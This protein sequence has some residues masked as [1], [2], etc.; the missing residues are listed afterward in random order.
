[1]PV[2]TGGSSSLPL[3]TGA[4]T[5][6]EQQSQ[7]TA[8]GDIDTN[9]D[10]VESALAL[11]LARLSPGSTGPTPLAAKTVPTGT[12]EAV[13]ASTPVTRFVRV[14]SDFANTKTVYVSG[15]AVTVANGQPLGPGDVYTCTDVNDAALI[16][17]ISADA[18]QV[19]RVEVL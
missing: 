9:T 13:A 16:Y 17:C 5:L 4:S 3:P 10:G 7:T 8:L 12:A 1:M 18:A 15:S 11:I 2:E 14:T 6:A 19:L